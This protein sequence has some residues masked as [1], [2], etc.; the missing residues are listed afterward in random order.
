MNDVNKLFA[1]LFCD[2]AHEQAALLYLASLL[3][4]TE[5]FEQYR[6]KMQQ[7]PLIRSFLEHTEFPEQNNYLQTL[8]GIEKV[9][10]YERVANGWDVFTEDEN[11]P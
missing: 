6:T 4:E 10:E 3:S 8:G 2:S 1:E 7:L 11:E 9:L 5:S